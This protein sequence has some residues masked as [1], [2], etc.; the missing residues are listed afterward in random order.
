MPKADLASAVNKYYTYS[1]N[2]LMRSGDQR[3]AVGVR[4]DVAAAESFVS[5]GL[6]VGTG[7]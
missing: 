1:V 5:R 4:D 6:R 7:R 2:L 3:V